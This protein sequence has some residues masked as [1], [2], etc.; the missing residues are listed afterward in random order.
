MK[1]NLGGDRIG[2][3]GKMNVDLPAYNRSTH[4]RGFIM[5]TSGSC[6]TLIP[7]MKKIGVPGDTWD[8][9]LDTIIMTQ[10]TIGPLFG[11][12]TID[13][14]IFTA[15]FRLYQAKLHNN[16][17]KAGLNMGG[18]KL[19][20][21]N[22]TADTWAGDS[23]KDRSTSQVN[24]SCV[25]AYL[26][27]RGIGI[28]ADSDPH[29]RSFCAVPWLAYWDIYKNYYANKQEEI[30]AVIHTEIFPTPQEINSFTVGTEDLSQ[31]FATDTPTVSFGTIAQILYTV[32]DANKPDLNQIL[33]TTSTGQVYTV[34][35]LFNVSGENPG[36]INLIYDPA[37]GDKILLYWSYPTPGAL[38]LGPIGITT[39]PLDNLD[40]MREFI[41]ANVNTALPVNVEL[42]GNTP[43]S[44][45][46]GANQSSIMGSQ[47]GLALKTYNSDIFN[48]WLNKE[49]VDDINDKTRV[50]TTSGG[51]TIEQLLLT[52]K[53]Y[54][55]ENRVNAAGGSFD[56]WIAAVWTPNRYNRPE[57][58]VYRGG[59]RRYLQFDPVVSN[60]A[61]SEQPLGT[62]AGQGRMTNRRKGGRITIKIDEPTVIMG[63]FSITPNIDYSQG[64]D[65]DVHLESLDDIHKPGMD[66]IGFQDLITEQQSWTTT[67]FNTGTGQWD[68]QSTGK[69]PAWMNYRTDYNRTYGDFAIP[70][71]QMFMTLNRRYTIAPNGDIT[72][73]TTYIDPEKYN[74]IFAETKVD[75]Q[76]FW[77]Q[78]AVDAEVR[79]L[80]DARIMPSM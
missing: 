76:N 66:R 16:K 69:Q 75:S 73:L 54:D 31:D 79:A 58:P 48:N 30:G 36:E 2:A 74:Q 20:I 32:G 47:E 18:I 37:N 64:N 60:S 78:I 43:Y 53:V 38:P 35:Q 63:M 52:Q 25:L 59:L 68:T 80:M 1:V 11:D 46:L 3:G 41:L 34:E 19:P 4:N 24:P 27:I 15:D 42:Y 13:L 5:R 7:F 23:V 29:L 56:D 26:G 6:G 65:W 72:D 40:E 10:P 67:K 28:N 57:T 9:D 62:L 50:D 17:L 61:T 14:H 44:L 70:T 8:I 12:Y 22:L 77:I 51:F 33:I 39:F 21:L 45:I 49:W 55:I 71:S